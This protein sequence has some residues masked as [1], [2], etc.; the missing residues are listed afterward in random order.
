PC[1]RYPNHPAPMVLPHS[2]ISCGNV[3]AGPTSPTA[4]MPE[5]C[6]WP[7]SACHSL[8]L[9]RVL[10]DGSQTPDQEAKRAADLDP[11]PD[12]VLSAIRPALPHFQIP[13]SRALPRR[14]S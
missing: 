8:G 3:A 11:T 13:S 5:S 4:T 6:C 14:I 2:C 1:S 12:L 7:H 10:D 9:R